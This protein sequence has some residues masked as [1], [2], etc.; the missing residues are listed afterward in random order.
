VEELAEK[1]ALILIRQQESVLVLVL[2]QSAKPFQE[3]AL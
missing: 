3:F 2:Q 1:T